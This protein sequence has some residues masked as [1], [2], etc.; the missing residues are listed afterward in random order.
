MTEKSAPR[1]FTIAPGVPFLKTLADTLCE[2]TLIAG[3]KDNGDPLCLAD[4]TIYVPT[5][6]AAR[7]LR[8]VFAERSI[9][10]AAILPT[11]RPLGEFEDDAGFFDEA[12]AAS[13]TLDPPINPEERI[14]QLAT[15]VRHWAQHLPGHIRAL[16]GSDPLVLPSTSADAVWLARN[17]ADLMDEVA[18]ENGDWTA[19]K[20]LVPDELAGWWQLTLEFMTI[21]SA[22]WP[23]YLK[24][25]GLSDP[26]VYRN[27][28][29]E[30]ETERLR[31][32][33]S[34]GPIIVA[35]STGSVPATAALLQVI[36]NLPQGAVVLPGLDKHMD[37]ESWAALMP[38]DN[39]PS[40][41]GHPQFG[42][43]KLLLG[44]K[45]DRD[46]VRQIGDLD[47]DI[48][49]RNDA[50]SNALLPAQSTYK[51]QA[52]QIVSTDQGISA[53]QRI[54]VANGFVNVSEI[55]ASN[56]SQEA[57]A[58][59]VALRDA[60]QSNAVPAALVTTDRT[61]ARRVSAELERFGIKADDSGG[62][63]LEQSPPAAL[64][65]LMLDVVFS[66]A[67]P[68]NL[69]SLLKHPL[70]CLGNERAKTRR[71][72]E[73]LEILSLRG[74][75]VALELPVIL[76]QLKSVGVDHEKSFEP[77]YRRRV[78]ASQTERA[79]DLAIALSNAL[80]PLMNFAMSKELVTVAEAC[81]ISVQAFENIG[82]DENGGL[83]NLYAGDAGEALAKHLRA[84]ISVNA[85]FTFE[86]HEWPS[87]FNALISGQTVKPR[88]GSDP[89]VHIWGA[90]EARLQHVETM[91]LG[92]LN[93]KTWPA[94]PA[95]DPLLS[96][97]MKAGIN[98]EPPERR[99]GLAA[100]DFQMLMGTKR[101]ILSRSVRLEGA[102][103]VPSRWLQRLH[104]SLGKE[105]AQ[106]MQE[107]AAHYLH[108]GRQLDL[109]LTPVTEPRPC[110][111]PALHL[112]PKSLSISEV[113]KLRRDPYAIHAKRIL[114][115]DPLEPLL[116][117]PDAQERG[118]LFHKIVEEF[119]RTRKAAPGTAA[120]LTL[121]GKQLF[122]EAGLPDD[123]RALWWRRFERM[124]DEFISFEA[125]RAPM[126]FSSHV[127]LSS[128]KIAIADTGVTLHGRADRIDIL[129][130][131]SAEVI[132]Y[133]TGT[134]PSA[135]QSL[136]LMEPQ[137]PLEAAL[138]ARGGFFNGKAV[139]ASDLAYIELKPDGEVK[140]KSVIHSSSNKEP[141][142][143]DLLGAR[144]WEEL[145][146]LV[147]YFSVKENGYV[148]RKAP[149]KE[150]YVGDYD[151]LARVAEWS[152][153]GDDDGAET[154]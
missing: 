29:V 146:K 53:D 152:G 33:G 140:A 23:Q 77:D 55:V 19:L 104:A 70:T 20:T 96:R 43:K 124:V 110:P 54:S 40:V 133:K 92:G 81:K 22:Q 2:G 52:A 91:V 10:K 121:L 32:E 115:L 100:H 24:D 57:L 35:G 153:G 148:S 106:A 83:A 90:L 147:R 122:D 39:T 34:R 105:A 118:Q 16:F 149:F 94:R 8:S 123:T 73:T 28:I 132:D 119:V 12:S 84:F 125:D 112:R 79:I 50:V 137:L 11:I 117:E 37:D 86:P 25:Q 101:V 102:P 30:A 18:R 69:L 51:W 66:P 138:L 150:A 87:I 154:P 49:T 74:G 134:A 113:S 27:I 15:L 120:E 68:V 144:A 130:G 142:T 131:G 41:F 47:A 45:I 126:I 98:I 17:L 135:L 75:V 42:L 9:S 99:V 13:L 48:A 78:K 3:F 109:G 26:V 58:I 62:T 1:V 67:D 14:V 145:I 65:R 36:A 64:F 97:G 7:A 61:L 5:R 139:A 108:W 129:P 116:R 151:H 141:V 38:T 107:R 136:S 31:R 93:E 88:T 63:P 128:T 114:G 111:T 82:R 127:E 76:E 59:A 103:S 143:A 80:A 89:R 44:F 21:V 95:D 6:R 56:E 85:D 46:H 71:S 4:V 60:I 72:A